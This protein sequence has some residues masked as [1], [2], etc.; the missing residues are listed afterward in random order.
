MILINPHSFLEFDTNEFL[1]RNSN[2]EWYTSQYGYDLG[3][4]G[5]FVSRTEYASSSFKYRNFSAYFPM[6]CDGTL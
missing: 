6:Y 2:S 5:F 1:F 3:R 4:P